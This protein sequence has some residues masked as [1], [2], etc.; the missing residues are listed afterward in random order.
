VE[1]HRFSARTIKEFLLP[2]AVVLSAAA[3]LAGQIQPKAAQPNAAQDT[4]RP[5]TCG[6]Q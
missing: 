6:P 5:T 4:A 2:F 3:Y 1:A